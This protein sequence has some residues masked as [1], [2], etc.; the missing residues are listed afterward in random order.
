MYFYLYSNLNGPF[1]KGRVDESELGQIVQWHSFRG[2]VTSLKFAEM[3][4]RLN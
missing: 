2:N 3:I 4:I 1:K